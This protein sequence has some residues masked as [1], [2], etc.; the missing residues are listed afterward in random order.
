MF[1]LDPKT[2]K[3][4]DQPVKLEPREHSPYFYPG[5]YRDSSQATPSPQPLSPPM[6]M[7]GSHSPLPANFLQAPNV[8]SNNF[9]QQ[10]QYNQNFTPNI[11]TPAP[12]FNNGNVVSWTNNLN[13]NNPSTSRAFTHNNNA[14]G[15]STIFNNDQ[16]PPLQN[17]TP[18]FSSSNFMDLDSNMLINN[19]SGDLSSLLNLE[20]GASFTR[21]DEMSNNRETN[22]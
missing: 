22:K 10:P 11:Q 5:T 3:A 15:Q 18:I 8:M 19:L 16:L 1:C 14:N 20:D 13:V 2:F 7:P 6:F 17:T 12:Q 21:M 9:P 4:I